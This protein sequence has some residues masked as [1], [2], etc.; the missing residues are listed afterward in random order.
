MLL[1]PL[2]ILRRRFALRAAAAD[3]RQMFRQLL[4]PFHLLRYAADASCA[5]LID[6]AFEFCFV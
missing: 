2:L 6:Y 4:L 5:T 1:T 3:E